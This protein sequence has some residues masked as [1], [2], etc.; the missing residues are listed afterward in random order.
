MN[1]IRRHR[2][3]RGFAVCLNLVLAF[4][5]TVSAAEAP[6]PALEREL[7]CC[8]PMKALLGTFFVKLYNF[9]KPV[10]HLRIT[11][12]EGVVVGY[13]PDLR[14][15]HPPTDTVLYASVHP[16]ALELNVDWLQ[17][18]QRV[19][20][21]EALP[22]GEYRLEVLGVDEGRYGLTFQPAGYGDSSASKSFQRVPIQ[23]GQTHVYLFRAPFA[24]PRD[25][26]IR[27]DD[28]RRFNVRRVP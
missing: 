1:R 8:L 10:A 18:R 6:A 13:N 25:G 24:D 16:D 19:L 21:L 28:P 11:T 12:P 15:F 23:A 5:A 20:A 17:Y 14:L 2:R 4:S 9:P 3:G 27:Q 7:R 22:P 26:S